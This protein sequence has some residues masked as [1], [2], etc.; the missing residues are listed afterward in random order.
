MS[1]ANL[2][3]RSQFF[4]VKMMSRSPPTTIVHKVTKCA[5]EKCF[6]CSINHTHSKPN[7]LTNNFF[8]LPFQQTQKGKAPQNVAAC[9]SLKFALIAHPAS[10]THLANTTNTTTATNQSIWFPRSKA[11]L[12]PLLT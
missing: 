12:L 10:N 11:T 1:P 2:R 9:S 7:T 5:C 6:L 3:W 4:Y 8:V